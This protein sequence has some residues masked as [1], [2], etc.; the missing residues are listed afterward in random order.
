MYVN[1]FILSVII[2]LNYVG[3][4]FSIDTEA[5]IFILKAPSFFFI[6]FFF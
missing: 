1:V 5:L 3:T 2:I 6:Q 4:L